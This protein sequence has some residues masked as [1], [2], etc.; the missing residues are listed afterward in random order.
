MRF[1]ELEDLI[2]EKYR[3]GNDWVY[4]KGKKT[5]IEII[6]SL[7]SYCKKTNEENNELIKQIEVVD[8][9]EAYGQA[10]YELN[11]LKAY[12][13]SLSRLVRDFSSMQEQHMKA[14]EE[15]EKS[16]KYMEEIAEK[17]RA[18]ETQ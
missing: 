3:D 16:Y 14:E 12:F 7:L 18:G 5:E 15:L 4:A 10:Q 1:Y 6:K 2:Y 13:S 11:K 17:I 9:W 8:H